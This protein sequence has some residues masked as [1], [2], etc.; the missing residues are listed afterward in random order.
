MKPRLIL[1]LLLGLTIALSGADAQIE[2]RLA[3]VNAKIITMNES[4]PLAEAMVIEGERIIYVG[5]SPQA[6]KICGPECWILDLNGLAVV[7]GFNDNHVHTTE[8]GLLYLQPNLSGKNCEEIAKIVAD[9][10]RKAATGEFVFGYNWDFGACPNPNRRA[11]DK[12]SPKNPVILSQSGGHAVWVNS[13]LLDQLKI[14]RDTPDPQGGKIDRD[15]KGEPTGVLREAAAEL[16]YTRQYFNLPTAQRKRAINKALDLYR[17]AGITSVQDNTWDPRNIW[18]L[19]DLKKAGKLTCRFTCWSLGE[20]WYGPTVMKAARFSPDWVRSGPVKLYMD[21]AFSSGTA[22]M[23][24]PFAEE[25][26]NLGILRRD[27]SEFDRLVLNA[28]EKRNQLA[29]QAIGDRAVQAALDAIERAEKDF[30]L[31]RD[32]RFRLEHVQ[33]VR[34]EDIPRF[35]KLGVLASVQPFALSDPEKD[36]RILGRDR[37]REAYPYRSL[38]KAGAGLSFGSD[39]P[40]EGDYQPLLGIYYAVTRR[41]KTGKAGP[42]NPDQCLTVREALWAYTLGSAY[43]EFMEKDKGSLEAGKLADFVVLNKSPFDVRADKIK[44]LEIK[45][46]FV[47]GRQ[48]WP[49]TK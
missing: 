27:Q 42:L 24:M 10:T 44:D 8:G 17:R 12:F 49:E 29:I 20:R 36:L 6:Q 39:F 33:T 13:N 15:E 9:E 19:S 26:A 34:P 48:V 7:P 37:A 30:P 25:P 11:L 47:G 21:G 28:A 35:S 38:L 43:A 18:M 41:N 1:V 3:V 4:L 23:F 32:L 5:A 2:P 31:S 40:A 14:T 16:A 45:Y 22:W 46:T